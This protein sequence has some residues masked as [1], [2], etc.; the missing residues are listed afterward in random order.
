MTWDARPISEALTAVLPLIVAVIAAALVPSR[1]EPDSPFFANQRWHYRDV[2]IVLGAITASQFVS[3]HNGTKATEMWLWAIDNG[4]TELL[5]IASVWGVVRWKHRRPWRALGLDPTTA[6]GNTLW[7]LRIGLG[8]VSVF[9]LFVVL[10][11]QVVRT[12]SMRHLRHT[13][14]CGT[15]NLAVSWQPWSS[16]RFSAQ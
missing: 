13:V 12:P 5:I 3:A 11:R 2:I 7:S 10:V 4:S 14:R 6:I 1:G 15:A 8:V 16:R 9:T